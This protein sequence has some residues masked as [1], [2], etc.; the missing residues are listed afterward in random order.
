MAACEHLLTRLCAAGP[1]AETSP[2]FRA[3]DGGILA[4][5]LG[6]ASMG[7][8][9]ASKNVAPDAAKTPMEVPPRVP[10]PPKSIVGLVFRGHHAKVA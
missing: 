10:I 5:T 2:A 8:L 3:F 7:V 1:Q 6:G 9:A 4:G